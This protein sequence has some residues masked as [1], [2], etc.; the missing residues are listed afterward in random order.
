MRTGSARSG[1][2]LLMMLG[3]GV[4]LAACAPVAGSPL[5]STA[6]HPAPATSRSAET[7]DTTM[8]PVPSATLPWDAGLPSVGSALA[9]AGAEGVYTAGGPA[10]TASSIGLWA[11]DWNGAAGTRS[12][13]GWEAAAKNMSI[14]VGNISTYTKWNAQLHSWNPSLITLAYNLGPYLQKGS[15]TYNQVL[16]AHP[17]WFAHG[18]HGQLINL[19]MFP[20]NYLMDVGNPAYRAWQAQQVAASIAGDGFNGVMIDSIGVDVL[21]HYASSPPVDPSTGGVYTTNTWLE[22]EVQLLDGD[23]TALHGGYLAF[24]GLVSGPQYALNSHI[25]ATSTADAGIAELFLRQ[26]TYPVNDFPST[27]VVQQTLEMMTD[28]GSQGKT[29][30]AWSKVWV[31]ASSADI[32][33]LEAFVLSVYLLGRQ[34]ASYLD[35][36]P[37]RDAD[38]TVVAYSN[39]KDALGAAVGPYSLQGS[40]FTRRFQAGSVTLNTATDT[41]L[42]EAT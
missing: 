15:Q 11:A 21:G 20:Q 9:A 30:L 13:A 23:K 42:I 37:S 36:M 29:F 31:S 41:A 22:D 4:V 14:L 3:L 27:S 32:S 39:L 5:G 8:S 25:L 17:T 33:R 10:S 18:S 34:S 38:N 16:Q 26:P 6:G 7:S 1:L 12:T 35:F 28:M 40:T 19:P 2:R 24:N